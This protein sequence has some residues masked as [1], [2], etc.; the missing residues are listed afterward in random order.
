[1]RRAVLA[2]GLLQVRT[3]VRPPGKGEEFDI[4]LGIYFEWRG[5]PEDGDHDAAALRAMVQASLAA[6]AGS[7]DGVREVVRPPKSRR[8][9]VHYVSA[10]G[11]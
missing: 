4:D 5:R 7:G 3:Q 9:R 6:Y 2:T 10:C 8:C 1:M 11:R